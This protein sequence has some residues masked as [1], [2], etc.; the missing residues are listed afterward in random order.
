M[1]VQLCC[2]LQERGV[3]QHVV[4]LSERGHHG[5]VLEAQGVPVTALNMRFAADLPRAIVTLVRLVRNLKPAVIQ[6]WMYHGN[7]MAGLIHLIALQGSRSRL[8]W[9]LRASNMDEKRYGW[10]IKASKLV[11]SW[12]DAIVA[13][14]QAGAKFHVDM[15][16]K[17]SSPIIVI[18]NGIDVQK[19]KPNPEIRE[20]IRVEFGIARDAV[21]ALHVA[22]ADPMKDHA[23]FLAAIGS[24]P[25][26][27][28][29][30]L[31]AG[32]DKLRL[33]GNAQALGVRH[34]V[35]SFYAAA[36]I[37]VSSSAFGEG[38]SNV[39]V[40]G[41]SAC[42]IPI[43]TDV[44]DARR[45]VGNVGWIVAPGNL[46]ELAKAISEVAALPEAE[47]RRCGLAARE[48]IVANFTLAQAVDAYA[49]LYA[50]G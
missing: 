32:T 28:A 31:G 24:T 29:L 15:G 12:P 38:F 40:E 25:A 7:L 17:P 18:G 21:V 23:T 49:R 42:L 6:G 36:D 41:M 9:N 4:S 48:R 2:A 10:L 44:G 45:I 14:S 5:D 30:L 1:L 13:N 46:E 43:A 50:A 39:I 8:L 35:L 16:Y 33:P 26:I 3:P 20:K 22:R 19:I 27:R 11:S 34:D 47:R 37:I